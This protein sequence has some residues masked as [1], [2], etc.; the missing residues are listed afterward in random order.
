MRKG[1]WVLVLALCWGMPAQARSLD[2]LEQAVR[3]AKNDT[4]R[5]NMLNDL[6]RG[7]VLA[8]QYEQAISSGQEA[9]RLSEQLSFDRGLAHAYNGLGNACREQGNYPKAL[10]YFLLSLSLNEKMKD[11]TGVGTALGNIGII[12]KDQQDFAKAQDYFNRALAIF[13]KKKDRI[14]LASVLNNLGILELA[15][16]GSITDPQERFRHYEKARTY[17][18]RALEMDE[19]MGSKAGI[20]IRYGNIASIYKGESEITRDPELR[21]SLQ[22][23]AL[24]YFNR[25]LS[26]NP[27]RERKSNISTWLGNIGDLYFSQ[28]RYKEAE[29]L[30]LRAIGMSDSLGLLRQTMDF[31]FIISELYGKQGDYKSSL[32]YYQ[33]YSQSRDSIFNETRNKELLRN[34]MNYEFEKKEAALQAQQEKKET[35][36]AEERKRQFLLLVLAAT[37]AAAGGVVAFVTLRTLRVTRSQKRIIELQKEI[38]ETKQK[39]VL[40]SIHYARRIQQSQLPSEWYIDKE[41]RKLKRP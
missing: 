26:V 8:N 12:Y 28:Q 33:L 7:Y 5:V 18:F 30:L 11:T 23:K 6:L 37:I 1:L 13:E 24:D 31:S 19:A 20:A 32:H 35:L 22:R 15:I 27:G 39:E 9:V 36:A 34:E 21:D 14:R 25:A 4:N 29:S 38:V 17:Y 16:N 41:L 3:K 2:S 10:E 40:D